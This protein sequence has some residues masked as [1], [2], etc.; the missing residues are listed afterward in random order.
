MCFE[1]RAYNGYTNANGYTCDH[2]F[3]VPCPAVVVVM[4]HRIHERLHHRLHCMCC[5]FHFKKDIHP[6]YHCAWVKKASPKE[7]LLHNCLGYDVDDDEVGD[8]VNKRTIGVQKMDGGNVWGYFA[9]SSAKNSKKGTYTLAP[10]HTFSMV[11]AGR[12]EAS[13]EGEARRLRCLSY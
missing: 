4:C 13:G 11:T 6:H 5:C 3:V 8:I 9:G 10:R 2:A 12:V 7:L 1:C